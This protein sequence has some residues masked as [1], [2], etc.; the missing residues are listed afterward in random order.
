MSLT[1]FKGTTSRLGLPGL[2]DIDGSPVTNATV[3]AVIYD[4]LGNEIAGQ[5]WPLLLTH[6][7]DGNY[8]GTLES[9]IDVDV[10]KRYEVE[11]VATASSLQSTW[12]ESVTCTY[13]PL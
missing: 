6:D 13:A 12:R 2:K 11:I 8:Y 1:L 9:D 10:G 3:E 7:S 5:S 4:R